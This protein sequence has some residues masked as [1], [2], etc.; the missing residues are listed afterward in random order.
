MTS[1]KGGAEKRYSLPVGIFTSG[2]GARGSGIGSKTSPCWTDRE[3]VPA[4]GQTFPRGSCA[5]C[6]WW[7]HTRWIGTEKSPTHRR[8]RRLAGFQRG[9][10]HAR[11]ASAAR[12]A[13]FKSPSRH[14]GATWLIN[15]AF[16]LASPTSMS[17]ERFGDNRMNKVGIV[18]TVSPRRPFFTVGSSLYV[19]STAG[20]RCYRRGGDGN[21][22]GP[23]S[24]NH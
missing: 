23:Q 11:V 3:A 12:A 10:H 15:R 5:H 13:S 18:A 24:A 19:G 1:L 4:A 17:Q 7:A 2:G 20:G 9:W 14:L 21:K 16:G 6:G 8:S 22:K